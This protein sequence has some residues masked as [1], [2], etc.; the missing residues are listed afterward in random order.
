MYLHGHGQRRAHAH[1][2]AEGEWEIEPYML[3]K[4]FFSWP[5]SLTWGVNRIP[6]SVLV[7]IEFAQAELWESAC[8][9]DLSR[10]L[11]SAQSVL[12]TPQVCDALRNPSWLVGACRTNVAYVTRRYVALFR[13]YRRAGVLILEPH[14]CL[15]ESCSSRRASPKLRLSSAQYPAERYVMGIELHCVCRTLCSW[16]STGPTRISS[17]FLL[18]QTSAL[19]RVEGARFISRPVPSAAP[20]DADLRP[21]AEGAWTVADALH[22]IHIGPPAPC[23]ERPEGPEPPAT[24]AAP[25]PSTRVRCAGVEV[26]LDTPLRWMYDRLRAPDGFLY[27]V[28][29]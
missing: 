11:A 12:P 24:P 20:E 26:P 15:F 6:V 1:Q 27:L 19:P 25:E 28:V 18:P 14:G 4:F 16:I 13:T 21:A 7:I 10:F 9:A 5:G 29:K 3:F 22:F 8:G 2:R 23:A 17:A